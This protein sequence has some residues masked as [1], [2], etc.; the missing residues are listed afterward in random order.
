MVISMFT[1]FASGLITLPIFQEDFTQHRVHERLGIFIQ[2]H[3]A[4]ETQGIEI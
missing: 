1:F 2:S 4:T 3:F